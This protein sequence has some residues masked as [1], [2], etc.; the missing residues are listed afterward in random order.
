MR[1][2]DVAD[3]RRL[4]IADPRPRG[5]DSRD[6][7]ALLLQP[8]KLVQEQEA[9]CEIDRGEVGDPK[10]RGHDRLHQLNTR[11]TVLYVISTCHLASLR[12]GHP[13]QLVR[14][15]GG[16]I[17]VSRSVPGASSNR[18]SPPS[19]PDISPSPGPSTTSRGDSR[20]GPI[21]DP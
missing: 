8:P 6:L 2:G 9:Q 18:S 19:S 10:G 17:L 12:G 4:Q 11:L 20:R 3:A 7:V 13:L 5:A 1:P 16:R 15:S 21:P 14:Q